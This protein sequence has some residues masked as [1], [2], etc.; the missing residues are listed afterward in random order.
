MLTH[1]FHQLSQF[2]PPKPSFTEKDIPDLN[3]KVYIVTGA[4]GGVGKELAQMLYAKNARVY[5]AAR[6]EEK[7]TNAMAAI[8]EAVPT[9]SGQLTFLSLDLADLSTIAASA[10]QFLDRESK[11]HVLFNNAGVM[12]P[13]KGSATAQ[14]YELQLGVNNIGTFMF[15]KLLTPTLVATAKSEEPGTVRVVWVASSAAEAP[16]VPLGGVD[17]GT[18]SK[19]LDEGSFVSYTLSKAGNYLHAVEM[20]KRFKEEGIISV[21]LNPGNLASDLWRTQGSWASWFLR[22]FVLHSP[23][24]GAYTELFAGL[25]P[26][27][28]MEKSG[29]WIGP[30]GRFLLIRHDLSLASKPKEEGGHGTS[31]TFWDWTEQEIKPY[32]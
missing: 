3:E 28:T 26:Q 7:A 15:T 25:S 5:L 11:L 20:A 13:A 9:S 32:L 23:V 29:N 4:S 1:K 22:T 6:S 12:N 30:W 19:R 8:K 27:V 21:P 31:K 14:N 24:Y 10:K 2:Y 16:S 17:M 18:I